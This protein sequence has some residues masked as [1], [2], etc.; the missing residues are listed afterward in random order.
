MI[1]FDV[2]VD[3]GQLH[4]YDTGGDGIPIVWHHGTP[5]LGAPPAPLFAAADRLGLRWVSYDRPG[6][7]GST[8]APGRDFASAARYTAALADHLGLDRFGVFGHSGGGPHALA[9]AALLPARVFGAVSVSGLAP[10]SADD[11]DWYAGMAAGSEATLRAAAA[12]RTALEGH[13][14]AEEEGVDIGFADVDWAALE[15]EW[16][17]FG[18]VV[19]PAIAT[20]PAALI[21]DDLAN[22]GAWGFDPAAIAVP[23]LLMHGDADRMVPSTHSAWLAAHI[24]GAEYRHWPADGHI[25]V[26][27][28]AEQALEWLRKSA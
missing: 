5:N 9:C 26:L 6:Y 11:L 25:S 7:G 18:S 24:P 17:W 28:H 27:H 14:A 21:D 23:V 13:L 20:G 22:T 2:P 1:E 4:A 16:G 3:G 19:G 15:G 8:P 12:G 10:I